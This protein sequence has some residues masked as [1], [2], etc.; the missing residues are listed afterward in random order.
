VQSNLNQALTR[1]PLRLLFANFHKPAPIPKGMR[2][3]RSSVASLGNRSREA[4]DLPHTSGA[5]VKS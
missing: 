1:V 3:F 4:L 2:T 5:S